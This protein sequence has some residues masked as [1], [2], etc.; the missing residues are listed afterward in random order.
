[1]TDN[2]DEPEN[3]EEPTPEEL[4]DEL[5]ESNY[6]ERREESLSYAEF[7]VCDQIRKAG[8]LFQAS[9][10][11]TPADAIDLV[12]EGLGVDELE[13]KRLLS[14]YTRIFTELSGYASGRADRAG[15]KYFSGQSIEEISE[16][17]DRTL[18]ETREDLRE[19]VGAY[20]RDHEV[21][22]V[23]LDQPI[24]NNPYKPY[25][26]LFDQLPDIEKIIKGWKLLDLESIRPTFDIPIT[27]VIPRISPQFDDLS[28]AILPTFRIFESAN[29]HFEDQ[30]IQTISEEIESPPDNWDA[31]SVIGEIDDE[32]DIP[33]ETEDRENYEEEG[34]KAV[35][36]LGNVDRETARK[37]Y[38]GFWD[39]S[40]AGAAAMGSQISDGRI[41]VIAAIS[42]I[43]FL[44][45]GNIAAATGF[46]FLVLE[47]VASISDTG[48]DQG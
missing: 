47:K 10:F 13:A 24:P 1:M 37:L 4:A 30:F 36:Q 5:F 48:E 9:E 35:S 22:V 33:E 7:G 40:R 25:R 42:T 6:E 26:E 31:Y 38:I 17:N 18:N 41:A 3:E 12:G 2:N 29:L 27:S 43:L 44:Y 20:I 46:M 21:D 23:D 32:E 19:F 8:E 28:D 11:E 39:A 45:T 16:D 34:S 14:I 15:R